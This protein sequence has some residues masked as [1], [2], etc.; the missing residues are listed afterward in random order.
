MR[1]R[2]ALLE[3]APGWRRGQF[4]AL[5]DLIAERRRIIEANFTNGVILNDGRVP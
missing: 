1:L 2:L 3:A 5:E 4:Q